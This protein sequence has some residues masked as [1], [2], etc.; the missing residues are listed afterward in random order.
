MSKAPNSSN[1]IRNESCTFKTFL[2][3][4]RKEIEK[5]NITK[6]EKKKKK[7]KIKQKEKKRKKK[8]KERA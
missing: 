7:K 3:K 1:T 6:R 8:E 2:K 5:K 4:R